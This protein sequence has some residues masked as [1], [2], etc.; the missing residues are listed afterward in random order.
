MANVIYLGNDLMESNKS[1]KDIWSYEIKD[2]L[3]GKLLLSASGFDSEA[4]AKLQAEMEI[5]AENIKGCNVYILKED[6]SEK[7]QA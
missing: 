4:D 6:N 3:S 2:V 7:K 1:R 5:K